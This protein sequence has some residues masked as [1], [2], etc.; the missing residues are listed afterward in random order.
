MSKVKL[1]AKATTTR[2]LPIYK[3]AFDLLSSYTPTLGHMRKDFKHAFGFR[4]HNDLCEVLR[5]IA[6]VNSYRKDEY[7]IRADN[8]RESE[9]LLETV[10]VNLRLCWEMKQIGNKKFSD[11]FTILD[12]LTQQNKKWLNYNLSKIPT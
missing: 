6:K 11:L 2:T 8:L 9:I 4:L 10:S 7:S 5:I 1:L 3:S 12:D